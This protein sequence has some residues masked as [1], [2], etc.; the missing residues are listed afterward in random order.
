M[1]EKETSPIL[2]QFPHYV[3]L[4][5]V[6]YQATNVSPSFLCVTVKQMLVYVFCVLLVTHGRFTYRRT[7]VHTHTQTTNSLE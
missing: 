6:C 2:I 1:A 3:S 4:F 5:S 7:N